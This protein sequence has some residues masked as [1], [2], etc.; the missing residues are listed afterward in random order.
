MSTIENNTIAELVEIHD[1]ITGVEPIGKWKGRKDLLV[2]KVAAAMKAARGNKTIREVAEALLIEVAKE[3]DGKP[4]GHPYDYVLD[5]VLEEFPEANTTVKC[6]RWYNTKLNSD[7]NVR[8]PVR[9]RKKV[10]K[11][12]APV[13][14]EPKEAEP[15]MADADP[16]A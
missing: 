13:T 2:E 9:P 10:V 5:R 11:A 14:E 15:V 12:E 8:M 1:G 4:I 6:L 3:E 16:L 7:P